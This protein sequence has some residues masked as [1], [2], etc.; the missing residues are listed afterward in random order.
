MADAVTPTA[1]RE[2]VAVWLCTETF[3]IPDVVDV[4]HGGAAEFASAE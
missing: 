1:D 3:G 2:K 4:A